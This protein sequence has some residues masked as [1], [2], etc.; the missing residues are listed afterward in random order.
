MHSVKLENRGESFNIISSCYMKFDLIDF[1][2]I[3]L[4]SNSLISRRSKIIIIA[5]FTIEFKG[6]TIVLFIL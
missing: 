2:L 6:S 1:C 5:K 4:K 3:T